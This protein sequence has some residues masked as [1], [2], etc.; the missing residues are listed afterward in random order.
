MTPLGRRVLLKVPETTGKIGSIHI[1]ES[2]QRKPQEGEVIAVG[3]QVRDV[4]VGDRVL[5]GRFSGQEYAPY[6][7]VVWERDLIAK[8][9]NNVLMGHLDA[10]HASNEWNDTADFL[11]RF[12]GWD[13]E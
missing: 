2:A 4:Q 1:P 6:G 11:A 3:D 5:F 8:F 9:G 10:L 12:L 13:R 7:V